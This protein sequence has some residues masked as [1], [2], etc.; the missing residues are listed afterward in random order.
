[1]YYCAF[2]SHLL[3][4]KNRKIDKYVQRAKKMGK[5]AK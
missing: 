2:I 4:T 1:M 5:Y 3:A